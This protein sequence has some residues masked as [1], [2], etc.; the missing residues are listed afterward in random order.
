MD[1]ESHRNDVLY[2][3][4]KGNVVALDK[5]TGQEVWRTKLGGYDLVNILVEEELIFAYAKGHVYCLSFKGQV[6]WDNGMPGLG[7]SMALLASYQSSGQDA[8]VMKHVK[9]QQAAASSSSSATGGV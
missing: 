3:G 7:Y 6:L 1:V 2:V 5:R 8:A 9:A 4:M